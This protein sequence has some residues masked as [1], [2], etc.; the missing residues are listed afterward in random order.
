MD[1]ADADGV[2]VT[3]TSPSGLIST[4]TTGPMPP[5]TGIPGPSY[6]GVYA[7]LVWGNSTVWLLAVEPTIA[8]SGFVPEHGDYTIKVDGIPENAEVHAYVARSDPNMGVRTGAKR[9]RFVDPKWEL[10]RSAK[11]SFTRVDGE[12]DKTGSLVRRDGTLNGIAT[13][14]KHRVHVA[15]GY[16]LADGRK[17]TFSSEGPA[18]S[19]HRVGPDFALPCDE[20]YALGGIR[21][22]GNRSGAVFRLTGTSA[23]APQLARQV[24]K[25]A[26]NLPIPP[27]TNVPSPNDIVEIEKRGGG[28]LEPP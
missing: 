7:P 25:L 13:A 19:G 4:S 14:K 11:A 28:N 2:T 9:S 8:A 24:T 26:R 27:P 1:N 5:P 6:T 10:T 15:G 22:G 21:A 12:F 20:S 17:S 3:L 23:A 16:V 18:R